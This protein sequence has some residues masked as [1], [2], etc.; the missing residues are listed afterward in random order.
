MQYLGANVPQA[1]ASGAVVH[2]MAILLG[3]EADAA[4]GELRLNPALPDWLPQIRV[5]QL[6]VG[7]A[8]VDLVVSRDADG[9]H[10]VEASPVDGDLTVVTLQE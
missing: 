8:T 7:T 10:K 5:D 2:L 6:T 1:W 4:A 3:L 9:T